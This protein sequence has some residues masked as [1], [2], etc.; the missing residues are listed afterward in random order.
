MGKIENQYVVVTGGEFQNSTQEDGHAVH[1][2]GRLASINYPL[3]N[4]PMR[5]TAALQGVHVA[6]LSQLLC[7]LNMLLVD[8]KAMC[9]RA[10][11]LIYTP[12]CA[13]AA[14]AAVTAFVSPAG[15]RGIGLEVSTSMALLQNPCE[16]VDA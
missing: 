9:S 1:R 13:A 14:A 10:A 3:V 11:L 2:Q 7:C 8:V 4:D 6:E 16:D 12:P 5:L 15:T